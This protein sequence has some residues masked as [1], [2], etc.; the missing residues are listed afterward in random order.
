MRKKAFKAALATLALSAVM[1]AAGASA[2][3]AEG[4][5]GHATYVGSDYLVEFDYNTQV[6]VTLDDSGKI[7]K[8]VDDGTVDLLRGNKEEESVK[9][10]ELYL[11][12]NGFDKYKGLSRSDI[13]KVEAVSGATE[14]SESVKSAVKKAFGAFDEVKKNISIIDSFGSAS[15][16]ENEEAVQKLIDTAKS[17]I[18][19]ATHPSQMTEAV[20]DFKNAMRNQKTKEKADK[21]KENVTAAEKLMQQI[22]ALGVISAD[23][24]SKVEEARAAY[25][26][27]NKAGRQAVKNYKKLLDAEDQLLEVAYKGKYQTLSGAAEIDAFGY[28]IGLKV[29]V[30]DEGKILKVID[31]STV[32]SI[33]SRTPENPAQDPR[34]RNL[35]YWRDSFVG[36]GGLTDYI[37]K[38]VKNY[39]EVDAI[40]QSTARH[41]YDATLKAVEQALKGFG[42]AEK[43]AEGSPKPEIS[44][45]LD[46]AQSILKDLS[47]SSWSLI[48]RLDWDYQELKGADKAEADKLGIGEKIQE[49]YDSYKKMSST[50][51][52]PFA[53]VS[54]HQALNAKN[55]ISV[56]GGK[57]VYNKA[58]S[59]GLSLEM[60][61]VSLADFSKV[62]MN[63][64][65]M[66]ESDYTLKDGS[67]IVELKKEYLDSLEAKEH[68]LKLTAKKGYGE[69]TFKVAESEDSEAKHYERQGRLLK[70][71]VEDELLAVSENFNPIVK[72]SEKDG[73]T[74]YTIAFK[75][76]GMMG[77]YKPLEKIYV[78]GK[79]ITA[80]KGTD[81]YVSVFTFTRN[82]VDE[83]EVPFTIDVPVMNFK[84]DVRIVWKGEK[85]AIDMPG[86]GGKPNVTPQPS[87]PEKPK[88]DPAKT[89]KYYEVEGKFVKPSGE[90]MKLMT[91]AFNPVIKLKELGGKAYYTIGFKETGMMGITEAL[92]A[93]RVDGKVIEVTPEAAPYVSRFLIV[94][95]QL[96]EKEIP[97]EILIKAMNN[98]W[99]KGKIVITGEKKAISAPAEP[100]KPQPEKPQPQPGKPGDEKPQVAPE[101]PG[102]LFGMNQVWHKGDK[103]GLVFTSSAPIE[104]FKTVRI[105]GKELVKD[106]DYTVV[107][108]STKVT[109]LP[110][111]L[112]RLSE[113][114]HNVEIASTTGSVQFKFKVAEAEKPKA[115]APGKTVKRAPKTGDTYQIVSLMAAGLVSMAALAYMSKK[116]TS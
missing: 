12:G 51:S 24:V 75:L 113:G 105:D 111:A 99:M 56:E 97:M 49:L 82:K 87:T 40:S 57:L 104:T 71:E 22:E 88:D 50:P 73:K 37:G 78:D 17:K 68:T 7:I 28:E 116:K 21:D 13:D 100:E 14:T 9:R 85:K 32:D 86:E 77:V 66:F 19:S 90:D 98:T 84:R 26:A 53:D 114:V 80:A 1:G 3:A 95:D 43:P 64:R 6:K 55:N 76:C 18:K 41:S 16:Y 65:L 34:T 106:V 96:D 33:N 5:S 4:A 10:W 89:P 72:L 109:V 30:S 8:V 107:S 45:L 63:G 94:R 69:I 115:K 92:S 36:M 52:Y 61:G 67:I 83:K 102:A 62:E 15:K 31:A 11:K 35:G 91:A 70:R 60:T 47:L 79:T 48:R 81:E 39:K 44:K 93:I 20:L 25:N 23:S 74:T 27:L 108:G 110:A 29:L 42:K 46:R 58:H 2:L 54:K 59:K 101:K 38:T 112:D 103:E